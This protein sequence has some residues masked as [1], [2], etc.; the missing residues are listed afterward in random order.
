MRP[1]RH[2]TITDVPG[3]RVG[4]STRNE[5]GWLTGCTI[6]VPP[7]GTVGGVDVRGG[8][9]GT[10]ETDLLSPLNL[11]D[12]VDAVLLTGGSAFGLAAA[13]GVMD[14]AYAAGL[15]WPVGGPD[16]R[17]PIVPAAVLF[18]LGRAGHFRHHPGPEDGRR[19]FTAA[20]ASA[21]DGPVALGNV[22]AGTGARSGGLRGG[23]GTASAVLDSGHTVGALVA[24]NSLGLP[25]DP[26]TGEL[27]AVRWGLE[28]EFAEAPTADPA[29]LAAELA[30]TAPPLEPQPG[31]ATTIGV[32]ATD[33]LLDK[34]QCTKLAGVSHDGLARAIAPVH[35][36]YD[37][38]TIF[39]LATGS[40]APLTPLELLGL[41]DAAAR[42]V[43]RAIVH[44]L[45]A[46]TSVV[47]T[48]DGGIAMRAWRDLA[49]Q[50]RRGT[51]A[52]QDSR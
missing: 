38:D 6:V 27:L 13:D 1:G 44:A 33:A 3:I 45:L 14:A 29:L 52:D 43:T 11:V 40:A 42:C 12:A 25:A 9:P 4:H 46:A 2:N 34:A 41:Q 18:D 19:A 36:A 28:D 15:G 20:W 17:V 31:Q 48:D 49:N 10:R 37:G 30:A 24:V 50:G 7:R 32:V 47:R 5:P 21:H 8:G 16:E 23:I 35:T 22:G 39:T 26:R 51:S